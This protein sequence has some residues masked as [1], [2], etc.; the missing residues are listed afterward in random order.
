L[1]NAARIEWDKTFMRRLLLKY[2][3]P[4][5]VRHVV[6]RT[7]AQIREALQDFKEVVVKPVGLTG[8]KGVKVSG[9]HLPALRDAFSYAQTWMKKDGV[10]LVEEKLE[11][12]E[13][14][15]QAFSDGA[16]ITVMP[17]VQDHKRV[18]I[19]DTGGNTGGM[20]SYSTGKNLPFLV[21]SDLEEATRILGATVTALAKE[22][23]PFRGV[24]Y[25]QFMAVADG[26]RVIEFNARF[27]DPEAINVLALLE[28][29][30][31]ETFA[32]MAEGR[33]RPRR[34][35]TESTVVK[36]LVPNGYP[37]HPVKDQP[38]QV[39]ENRLQE[40]GVRGYYASVYENDHTIYCTSSRSMALLGEGTLEEAQQKAEQ[41]CQAVQGPLFHRKDIGT[42]A[43]IE[44]RVK[45]MRAL[46][47]RI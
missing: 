47:R 45:H 2:N 39:D 32:Q 44:K 15:L 31:S 3:I 28:D 13:F 33:L 22:G 46:R 18:G 23:A 11:G 20:G 8:G 21:S 19:G 29:S 12:E 5:Q 6:A 4:G 24:L 37:E 34:F 38:L 41:G 14:T 27:G 7:D 9:E 35:R 16:H 10:V 25:G 1:K 30:L 42:A 17:P 36:Y 40:L 43:L 26:V